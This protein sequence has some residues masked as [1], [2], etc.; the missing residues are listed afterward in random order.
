MNINI[1]E[2]FERTRVAGSIAA[3]ALDE[4]AK[5]VRPGI[6]T[7][8]IDNICYEFIS[9]HGAY[10]APLFYRG[11]PKSS[12]TSANHVVCHGIPSDK[13]LKEGDILN[14]DV[15]AVKDGWHGDTS[16]MFQVGKVS[17]KAKKLIEITYES[18]MKAIKIIKEDI[19]LGDIGS[20]IQ[21]HVEA[22]GFSVVQDFCGHGIG[23]KFHKEP[24]ILHYGKK[25]T[26]EKIK[27]GMIF[28]VEPMINF[29]NYETKVLNDGWTAV[30]KDKSLS[31]QFEHT[32]GVTKDGYEIFT[33][34]QK[35]S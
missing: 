2:S 20:T 34:S 14:V 16:R 31:A 28:T 10:S 19:Q 30:T 23:Q 26:G 9:D 7:G 21:E 18:M 1:K 11:F 35:L 29:G 5:V 22:N 25:G 12:C 32:V 33:Q 27:N 17:V 6:T 24:N 8:E 15:T 13:T 4:V 3:G